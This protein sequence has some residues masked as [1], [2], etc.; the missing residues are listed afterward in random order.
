MNTQKLRKTLR[1]RRRQLTRQTLKLHSRLM[2]K[3]ARSFYPLQHSQR[4][5]FYFAA[6][7][8]MDPSPL[9]MRAQA[10]GK[11]CYF[12]VLR[13]RPAQSL[14]F[15]QYKAKQP[16]K[17]NR[18]GIPEP[19]DFHRSITMPWALDLIILPLVAFDLSGN[20]LGMG[21][22]FYDRTLSFKQKRAHWK[23]PKLIGIAHE[24]QRVDHLPANKW[25]IPLD[26]VITEKHLYLFNHSRA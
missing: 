19:S 15:A 2:G 18:F 22:G 23:G 14:W 3:Q 26:A 17:P 10:T 9:V 11:R 12:P 4:I 21:G 25:D 20:R 1:K 5:A 24:L 16:L 7:G 6:D 13:S 8:E